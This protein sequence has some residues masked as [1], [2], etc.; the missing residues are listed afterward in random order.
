VA[1]PF[2]FLAMLAPI[3]QV[4][5]ADLRTDAACTPPPPLPTNWFTRLT[6]VRGTDAV[7]AVAV[8]RTLEPGTTFAF[9]APTIVVGASADDWACR[10]GYGP[11]DCIVYTGSASPRKADIEYLGPIDHADNAVFHV[12]PPT[13]PSGIACDSPTLG[14]TTIVSTSGGADADN[15]A[16]TK[17]E[18][19]G[20]RGA[21]SLDADGYATAF[22]PSP[23]YRCLT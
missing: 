16:L 23:L 6:F 7:D 9:G 1:A 20:L 22:S 19:L 11:G 21:V 18:G 13:G 8:C 4:N 14:P 2:T 15:E 17:C 5:N 10:G 12:S 3:N